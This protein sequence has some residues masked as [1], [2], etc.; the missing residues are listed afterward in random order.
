MMLFIPEVYYGAGRHAAYIQPPSNI[1]KGLKLNFVTQPLCMLAIT[2]VKVS[3]GLFL[4]RLTPTVI[5]RRIIQVTMALTCAVN[6]AYIGKSSEGC[7]IRQPE[8]AR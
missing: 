7:T 2:L 5:Y 6:F 8:Q 3:I 4:L 1:S